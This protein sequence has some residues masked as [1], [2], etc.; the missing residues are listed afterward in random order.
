MSYSRAV[1][2]STYSFVILQVF[3]LFLPVEVFA[4]NSIAELQAGFLEPRMDCRPHTY[5]WW[6]GNAVTK[7][8]ITWELEQMCE[9]GIGGVLITSAAPSVYEKGN[10]P[11]LSDEHLE[12]LKHAVHTAKRLNMDVYINF[13]AR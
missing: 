13:S 5:W 6:P 12:M 2:R 4:G 11:Y 10:I 8:H 9:K 7:E 1:H 3:L